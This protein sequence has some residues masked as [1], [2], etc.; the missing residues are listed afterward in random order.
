M[1]HTYTPGLRVSAHTGLRKERRLPITGEVLVQQGDRVKAE[2]IVARAELP[3]TVATVN[4]VSL[5]GIGA[6]EIPSYMLK[7][8]GA[9]VAAE[10]V[11]AQTRPFL[12]W[13]RSEAESPI[14]GTIET[15][16]QVT[17]QVILRGAPQPVELRAYIDGE[18]VEVREGEGVVVETEGALIQGILGV[19]GEVCGELALVGKGRDATIAPDDLTE[20]MAGKI[21]VAGSFVSS[22][23]FA[24]ATQLGIVGLVCGGF[25]DIDLRELLGRDLGV[26]I[27]GHEDIQPILIITEGFG[28][29]PMAA[30]TYDLFAANAGKRASASGATQIRAGV[31]RPEIIIPAEESAS[32]AHQPV[33]EAEGV[34]LELGA[35]VRIIREPLFGA[36]G[37][38]K[39]LPVGLATVESETKVRVVEITCDDGT[40]AI[41][42][43]SNVEAI[44]S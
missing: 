31:M 11:I 30:A 27:T 38:V 43:R 20:A 32:S 33:D 15:I 3:G 5:L 10:E 1:S 24:R 13:F 29:I 23:V 18:V 37:Q 42:P 9:S 6:A 16:S 4:V 41:V 17:G 8:E 36:L 2:D 25:N 14:D 28:T 35:R 40:T 7:Q 21:V 12:S 34:G 39:D 19:G 44:E 22:E 26:A